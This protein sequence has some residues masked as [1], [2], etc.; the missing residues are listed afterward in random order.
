MDRTFNT[1]T[2]NTKNF[3]IDVL[4]NEITL[5]R[6]KAFLGEYL[7]SMMSYK[8]VMRKVQVMMT[9]NIKTNEAYSKWEAFQFEVED[10]MKN[11]E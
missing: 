6:E 8:S 11:V 9:K 5:A 4:P 10:E 3:N 1:S 7:D 2:F